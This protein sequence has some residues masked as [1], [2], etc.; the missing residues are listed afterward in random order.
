MLYKGK[1]H[2]NGRFR[3]TPIS[4]NLFIALLSLVPVGK[5]SCP[6]LLKAVGPGVRMS[7]VPS[8]STD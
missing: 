1:S 3:G 7:S 4:G 6:R 8:D 2:E 5:A